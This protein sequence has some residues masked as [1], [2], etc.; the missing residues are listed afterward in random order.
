MLS[1]EDYL[2]RLG[3]ILRRD[4][5]PDTERLEAERDYLSAVDSEDF[6]ALQRAVEKM[7]SI[8]S[9]AHQQ[10]N[11]PSLDVFH[12]KYTSEDNASFDEVLERL[13]KRQLAMQAAGL[14]P[15]HHLLHPGSTPGLLGA[16]PAVP[17]VGQDRK[18]HTNLEHTRFRVPIS[19]KSADDDHLSVASTEAP[20]VATTD[21]IRLTPRIRPTF[22]NAVFTWGTIDS[23]PLRLQASEPATPGTHYSILPTP[24]REQQPL[25]RRPKVSD[26]DAAAK[27]HADLKRKQNIEASPF[28]GSLSSVSRTPRRK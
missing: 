5:F 24:G 20:T 22:D 6:L 15:G 21:S 3:S 11:L 13:N 10:I 19:T 28:G 7:D 27:R 23:T 18:R 12:K 2:S 17:A 14:G 16:A 25:S 1:E 9:K 4:F 8:D 26:L